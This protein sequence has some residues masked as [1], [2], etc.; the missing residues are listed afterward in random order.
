LRRR[1]NDLAPPA[2]YRRIRPHIAII[3]IGV[4]DF[5]REKRF[6]RDGLGWPILQERGEWVCFSLAD[7]SSAL[8]LYPW[9]QLAADAG[10]PAE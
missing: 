7:G 5:D 3:G 8:T 4:R 10:V 9:D 2:I 6:Y 1:V